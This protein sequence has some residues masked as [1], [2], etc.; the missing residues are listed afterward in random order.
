MVVCMFST[1]RVVRREQEKD[2]LRETERQQQHLF[3]VC[4]WCEPVCELAACISVF[5][6]FIRLSG[7]SISSVIIHVVWLLI[8]ILIVT[9]RHLIHS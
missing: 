6:F 1:F 2:E 9:E 4:S 7:H 8:V 5:I 3:L